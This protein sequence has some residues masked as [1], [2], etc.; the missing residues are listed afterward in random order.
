MSTENNPIQ[1]PPPQGAP[2]FPL[3]SDSLNEL[4]AA[5]AKAQGAMKPAV[6]DAN[7]P[8]F[9]SDYSTL[10]AVWDACRDPLSSNGLAVTQTTQ[11]DAGGKLQL[12]TKLLHVSGQWIAGLYPILAERPTPQSTASGMTYARR[13]A[14][15]GI[16]G[17]APDSKE[18][19]D[20]NSANE[21]RNA[22]KRPE[23]RAKPAP[24]PTQQPPA[25]KST[26][27]PPAV[28]NQGKTSGAATS[29]KPNPSD[30]ASQPQIKRMFA[31][32]KEAGYTG[33][34]GNVDEGALKHMLYELFGD[35]VIDDEG[36]DVTCKKLTYAMMDAVFKRLESDNPNGRAR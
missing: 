30:R 35:D 3:Q 27:P 24:A 33:A 25:A 16:V 17:I 36:K 4:T 22:N 6:K 10:A 23:Q 34:D 26:A 20:G 9:D 29:A 18:D 11:T 2:K 7:N 28:K 12:L 32:A 21:T 15:M 31:M 8:H 5:L 14:L 13:N 1:S 19:D